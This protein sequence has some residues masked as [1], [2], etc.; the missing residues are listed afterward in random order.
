[1]KSTSSTLCS[2][3]SQSDLPVKVCPAKRVRVIAI[4]VLGFAICSHASADDLKDAVYVVGTGE[5]IVPSDSV[6]SRL[7]VTTGNSDLQETKSRNDRIAMQIY[8]LADAQQ[9]PRPVLTSTSLSFD[10]DPHPT[11]QYRGKGGK[12]KRAYSED[13]SPVPPIQMLR[14][15]EARFD[16]LNQAIR[17]I[18]EVV[19]WESVHK[20]RELTLEP[21]DFVVAHPHDHLMEARR[22]AV[23]SAKETAALLAERNGLELGR[24]IQIYDQATNAIGPVRNSVDDPFAAAGHVEAGPHSIPS[25]RLVA[26]GEERPREKFDIDHVPPAQIK[27]TASVKIVFEVHKPK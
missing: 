18:G 1:M 14:R 25:I 21:L 2:Q 26:M 11:R 16:D 20:T 15:I 6:I 27:I 9:I 10:F 22:R 13:E 3:L 7:I 5:V 4:I 12:E 17:F 24:A 19:K 23:A 8:E